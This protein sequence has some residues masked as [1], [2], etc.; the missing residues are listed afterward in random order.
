MQSRSWQLHKHRYNDTRMQNVLR[1]Y[2]QQQPPHP[3]RIFEIS[4]RKLQLLLADKR[5]QDLKRVQLKTGN[6]DEDEDEAEATDP[7]P[8][9]T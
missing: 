4:P 2:H 1:L 3:S 5:P 7:C 8:A 9:G 6:E